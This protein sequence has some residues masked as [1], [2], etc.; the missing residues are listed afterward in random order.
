MPKGIQKKSTV[1]FD[2]SEEQLSVPHY[3]AIFLW[4]GWFSFFPAISCLLFFSCSFWSYIPWHLTLT[5]FSSMLFV[6]AGISEWMSLDQNRQPKVSSPFTIHIPTS[7]K[8]PKL[9]TM[10]CH[11]MS[12]H[13]MSILCYFIAV[14]PTIGP[15]YYNESK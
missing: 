3:A 5:V 13:A 1:I 7:H 12:C 4:L 9:I 10:S 14:G 15:I 11:V 6:S 2:K 8:H